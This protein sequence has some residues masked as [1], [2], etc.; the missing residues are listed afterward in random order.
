MH[1]PNDTKTFGIQTQFFYGPS[2]LVNP[3]TEE[4]S[5]SVSFYLPNAIWY[6]FATQTSVKGGGSVVT[7]SGVADTDIPL[8]IRGGSII[9]LRVKS[10]MTTKALREQDFELWIAPGDDGSAIGSLYLDD[11]ESLVQDGISEIVLKFD[12]ETI[13]TEGTFEFETR[14]GVKS[15]TILGDQPQKYDLNKDLG[16]AWESKI[17]DLT[18]S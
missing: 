9:P 5:T 2:I 8:L 4:S 10:A 11:G 16:G 12:G 17:R 14:V 7:Y 13:K 1:Y 18:K 6:D 3:I 15:V